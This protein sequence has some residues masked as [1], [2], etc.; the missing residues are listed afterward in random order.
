MKLALIS[1]LAWKASYHPEVCFIVFEVPQHYNLMCLHV[2][3]K[4][5]S[6]HQF[7]Y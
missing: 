5:Y 2:F 7:S 1:P 3:K 4:K 6:A